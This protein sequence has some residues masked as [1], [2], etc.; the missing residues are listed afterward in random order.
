MPNRLIVQRLDR[1]T[2]VTKGGRYKAKHPDLR[3]NVVE[4]VKAD[5]DAVGL[6]ADGALVAPPVPSGTIPAWVAD[7]F[8]MA[9]W[10]V[11]HA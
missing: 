6:K 4:V 1:I 9:L 10:Q 3:E 2:L 5:G 8:D 11:L 7:G